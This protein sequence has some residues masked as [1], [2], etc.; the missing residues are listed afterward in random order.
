MVSVSK[1][2]KCLLSQTSFVAG[3]TGFEPVVSAV[4]GQRFKPLS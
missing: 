3:R 2:K 4:T 1:I